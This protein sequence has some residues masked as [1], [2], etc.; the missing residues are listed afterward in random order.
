MTASRAQTQE[1]FSDRAFFQCHKFNQLEFFSILFNL[2]KSRILPFIGKSA[3]HCIDR[4]LCPWLSGSPLSWVFILLQA[5]GVLK[6]HI[7]ASLFQ[8]WEAG[9]IAVLWSR[10]WEANCTP[11]CNL[12]LV[13]ENIGKRWPR[14]PTLGL[15]GWFGPFGWWVMAV[16]PQAR[17]AHWMRQPSRRE[18]RP[19]HE[20]ATRVRPRLCVLSPSTFVSGSPVNLGSSNYEN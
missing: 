2:Q 6:A 13:H 18:P 11:Q 14:R 10:M 3:F 17:L 19:R 5:L 4:T 15:S 12:S 1:L 8:A 16:G 9:D 20:A 7:P